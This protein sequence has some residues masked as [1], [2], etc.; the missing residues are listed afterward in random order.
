MSDARE[1]N[2]SKTLQKLKII[3]AELEVIQPESL[4][5]NVDPSIE[6]TELIEQI[7]K[8]NLLIH[9]EINVVVNNPLYPEKPRKRN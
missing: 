9:Q 6:A 7:Q 4:L 2:Q 1:Q 8:Y 3:E 5:K